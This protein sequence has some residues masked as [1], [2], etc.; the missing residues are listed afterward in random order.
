MKFH[1]KRSVHLYLDAA[2]HGLSKDESV[3]AM[4]VDQINRPIQQPG[5]LHLRRKDE[6]PIELPFAGHGDIDIA[7][8]G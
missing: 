4:Q 6:L 5:K 3:D 2:D 1:K 8:V 7:C